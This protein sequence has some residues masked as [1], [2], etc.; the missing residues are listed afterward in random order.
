MLQL[1]DRLTPPKPLPE[2]AIVRAV[3]MK[4]TIDRIRALLKKNRRL[5]FGELLTSAHNRTEVIVSFLALLELVKQKAVAL[6][7]R[8]IFSDIVIEKI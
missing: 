3:S 1:V 5:S 7:Q 8:E 2:T 6:R 4:E